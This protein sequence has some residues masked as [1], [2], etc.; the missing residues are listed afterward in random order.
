[1]DDIESDIT[2]DFNNITVELK[3]KVNIPEGIILGNLYNRSGWEIGVIKRAPRL[4]SSTF[5]RTISLV[6]TGLKN[7]GT[8]SSK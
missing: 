1:M 8:E 2:V 3:G 6:R 5:V 7:Q 4:R